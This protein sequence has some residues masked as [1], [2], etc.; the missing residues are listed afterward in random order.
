[1]VTLIPVSSLDE[2][3]AAVNTSRFGLNTAIYTDKLNDVRHY[4]TNAQA[5]TVLV[6]KPPSYRSD[7]MP[8]GGVK[9]SGEAERASARRSTR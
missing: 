3:V 7:H 4:I 9:E 5:G 8:Y 1:M 6:N 2:A